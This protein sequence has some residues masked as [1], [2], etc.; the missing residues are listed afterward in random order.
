[1][2]A[3]LARTREVLITAIDEALSGDG[4]KLPSITELCATAGVS[5]PTFY[6]HFRDVPALVAAAGADEL[7]RLFED[8]GAEL[9]SEGSTW[10]QAAPQVVSRLLERLFAA[11]P[12]YRRVLAES[13]AHAFQDRVISFLAARL[14]VFTP[15]AEAVDRE[16][17]RAHIERTAT[18][19]AAGGTWLVVGWL[20]EGPQRPSV[21]TA[22][23]EVSRLLVTSIAAQSG[24]A[25]QRRRQD[26]GGAQQ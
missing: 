13:D 14:L 20:K 17:D 15:L 1:M 25:A 19:L 8:L 7:E 26:E 12:Y 10:E 18:F 21:E 16:G 4:E 22:A 11:A 23:D 5:R 9:E 2:D 24:A 3:R 6:Q